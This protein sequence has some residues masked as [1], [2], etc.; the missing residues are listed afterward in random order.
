MSAI[1]PYTRLKNFAQY[2]ID[3]TAAPYNGSDHDAELNAIFLT[4]SGVVTNLN[5][6]QRADGKLA[7]ASVH[8]DALSTATMA[9]ISGW[10]PRGLW[11]TATS[12]AVKDV[13]Q[14]GTVS[15]V[16]AVAHTSGTFATDQAAGKWITL[17]KTTGDT[18]GGVT[19]TPYGHLSSTDV[20]AAL[21][22]VNDECALL[23]GNSLQAFLAADAT[24]KNN[25]ATVGQVQRGDLLYAVA[26]GT[27]DALTATIASGETTLKD[28]MR[29]SVKAAS[30]NGTTAPTL[31]LT[32][33]TTATGAKTCKKGAGIPVVVGDIAGAEH[34]LDLAYS[35]SLDCWLLL[36]P[37]YPIGL[38]S[39][40]V[41]PADARNVGMTFSVGSNALSANITTAGGGSPSASDQGQVAMRSATATA[42]TY[43]T[44]S[45]QAAV[46]LVV[47]SGATL[48]HAS[49]VQ[50]PL[51][52]YL[53][54]NAGTLEPAVSTKFFGSSGIVSTT[55]ITGAAA[56]ATTMYSTTAR[57]SVPFTWIGVSKDKQ[58][59]AGTWTAVPT[60][61]SM[62]RD[63]ASIIPSGVVFD[64]AGTVVPDGFLDCD[65]SAVSRT[66][67]ADLF[68]AIG[69]TWG[70]GDGSTTFNVPDFRRRIAVGSGG[71]GTGTLGNAVGNTGG[72]ETHTL[73]LAESP[74]HSHTASNANSSG[75]LGGGPAPAGSNNGG[76]AATSS[77]TD[78]QGGGG[79]HNNMQ[80]SAVVKKCI[81]T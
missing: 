44:R 45:I 27:S 25:A 6:I 80:P 52:W 77:A 29:V 33:G 20:Q 41:S 16:C 55:Q 56:S 66:T 35:S 63:P 13:V 40:G 12:Y 60:A 69:T 74:A 10:T 28:G 32:L 81:K 18:A 22:E 19:F 11:L 50:Q 7:N 43:N 47:P 4:L 49:N 48:G 38:S 23:G 62:V 53:I 72:A 51:H 42:A 2:A 61:A 8:P 34:K 73:T 39:V 68:A 64:Y 24:G 46:S 17:G 31:N 76:G 14:Q 58:T 78:S 21:Q 67:F 65:A 3:H 75:A 37:A 5:L 26:A 9:L 79:A 71:S 36:N 70:A 57:A 15:Y 30:A 59:T 1:T 54:D